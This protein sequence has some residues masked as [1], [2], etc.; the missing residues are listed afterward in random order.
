M[1]IKLYHSEKNKQVLIMNPVQDRVLFEKLQHRI[2]DMAEHH[3]YL[4]LNVCVNLSNGEKF[5][6]TPLAHW[7]VSQGCQVTYRVRKQITIVRNCQDNFALD[8]Q[9]CNSLQSLKL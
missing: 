6:P 9:H 2:E 7:F 4:S 3:D 8:L 5:V 1:K